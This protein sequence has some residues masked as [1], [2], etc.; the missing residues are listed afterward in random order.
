MQ[1]IIGNYISL[2]ICRLHLT[3]TNWSKSTY[4]CPGDLKYP[5]EAA[6]T[7]MLAGIY[8]FKVNNGNT[9]EV[10]KICSKLTIKTPKRR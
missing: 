4:K 6:E 10:C 2:L 7:L 8:L 1:I 5:N 3:R 9:R